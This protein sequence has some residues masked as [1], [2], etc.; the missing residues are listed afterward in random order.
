MACFQIYR[1]LLSFATFLQVHSRSK[2]VSF[3]YWQNRYL[4]LKTTCH[5]KLIFFLWT[6]LLESLLLAKYLMSVPAT[7]TC[8][9]FKDFWTSIKAN[10]HIIFWSMQRNASSAFQPSRALHKN[11]SFPLRNST[12]NPLETAD[13]VIFTEEIL[14]GKL[15]FVCSVGIVKN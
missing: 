8:A 13:L 2:K 5:I 4:N 7:L 11:W 3:L 10:S 14:N 6:K 9:K 12:V 1:E 15:H